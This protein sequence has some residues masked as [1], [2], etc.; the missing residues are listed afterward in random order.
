MQVNEEIQPI[1]RSLDLEDYL[2]MVRRHM[3]WIVGPAFAGLVI[4][5]VVAFLWPDTYVSTATIRIVPPQVPE[6]LVPTNV[7]T[8]MAE[9]IN[10]MYQT[11]S[12]RSNLTNIIN[13]YNLY[14]RERQRKPLEDVIEQ[15]RQAIRIASVM[16]VG[17]STSD[18]ERNMPAFQISFTYENRLVAQK[19]TADLVSRFMTENTRE[20]TAQSVLTTQFL[21]DQLDSAKKELDTIENQLTAYRQAYQGRLP[22]QLQQNHAQLNMLEQRISNINNAM[23]RVSQEK[24]LLESDL[25]SLR[26]QQASLTPAPEAS[27]IRQRNAVLDQQDREILQLEVTLANLRE[28]YKDSYPDVQRVLT[29]LN[30]ARKIREKL[31][32]RQEKEDAEEAAAVGPSRQDP[33]LEREART[34]EANIQRIETQLKTRALETENYQKEL[35]NVEKQIRMVQDRLQ[36]APASEQQYAELIRDYSLA[37]QKYEELNRKKAQSAIAEELERRQQGETLELLDPASLPMSPTEPNRPV[38]IGAGLAIGLVLGLGLVGAREAKDHTLKNLKDVRAYTQLNVLGSI[39]LLEN[40]LVVRRRRRLAWLAWSTV[41]LV[42]ILIM[43]AAV[44]YYYA[45]KV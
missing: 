15:M 27:R 30:T 21:K 4:A 24:L 7:N 9:R 37:K 20:R 25:R 18:K 40:D 39:P 44:L 11:V 6:N 35:A 26:A 45:T 29:Q 8:A 23:S 17:Q 43:T 41:C 42:G 36:A 31:A 33:V 1:R 12:S 22:E 14:S 3:A 28:H 38:I 2:D 16:P 5:V 10:A 19:V 32:V 34:I 13:S